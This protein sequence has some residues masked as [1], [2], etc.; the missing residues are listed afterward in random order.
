MIFPCRLDRALELMK[1]SKDFVLVFPTKSI[2]ID[3]EKLIKPIINEY[4]KSIKFK[5]GIVY[6]ILD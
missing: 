6:V 5:N 3:N 4:V 2:Y 1:V